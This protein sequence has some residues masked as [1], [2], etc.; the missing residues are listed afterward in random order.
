MPG[1]PTFLEMVL[2][3]TALRD[4]LLKAPDQPALFA[5]V[6]ALARERGLEISEEDLRAVANANRRSWLE[7]WTDQ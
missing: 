7:R 6:L 2:N 1:F 4:E 3:D 5:R